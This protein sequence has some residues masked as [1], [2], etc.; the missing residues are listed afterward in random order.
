MK[1]LQ[2]ATSLGKNGIANVMRG[3]SSH[4]QSTSFFAVM[5]NMKG[6]N[7]WCPPDFWGRRFLLKRVPFVARKSFQSFCLEHD[8]DLFLLHYPPLDNLAFHVAK[9]LKKKVAYYYHNVTDPVFYEG[10][11]K[12]R[13]IREDENMLTLISQVDVVFCNS[14]F[15]AEKVEKKTGRKA[16]VA[17]PGVD[18]DFF[19]PVLKKENRKDFHLVHVGRGV[20]HKGFLELLEILRPL[21][22][23][24]SHLHFDYAGYL[25]QDAYAEKCRRLLEHE[26]IHFWENLNDQALVELLRKA[27]V[28]VSASRFE[29][30][31]MP[32]LEAAACGLPSLGY[33]T[34]AIP[35]AVLEGE[36]GCLLPLGDQEAFAAVLR[37]WIENPR[38]LKTLSQ[39]ARRHALNHSWKKTAM[40]IKKILEN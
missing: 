19:S 24:Y 9:K 27:D 25:G 36:S 22:K 8:I 3:I 1:L 18:S 5:E 4:W 40:T 32:F 11:E 6:E 28:F 12:T 35:E 29:G 30:F 2:V 31:G 34:A 33:R 15:T 37:E 23:D 26:R 21:L 16:H 20:A 39:A 14:A 38:Q 17:F 7:I 13:R 10:S